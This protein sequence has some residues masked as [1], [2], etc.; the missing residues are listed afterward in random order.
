ANAHGELFVE[1]PQPDRGSHVDRRFHAL[2]VDALPDVLIGIEV[3]HDDDLRGG[4]RVEYPH[5]EIPRAGGRLP[6]HAA[7]WISR[8]VLAR[9][10]DPNRI[11]N[12]G[13]PGSRLPQRLPKWQPDVLRTKNS[14]IHY[15]VLASSDIR[16][17]L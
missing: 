4:A 11:L 10:G 8:L 13:P 2:E 12:Q 3:G 15:D 14:G 16:I 9:S 17:A 5:L 7:E 6:V 1:R